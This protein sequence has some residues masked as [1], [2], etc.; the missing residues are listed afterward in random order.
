ML[1][2]G[3]GN[4]LPTIFSHVNFAQPCDWLASFV[5]CRIWHLETHVLL[6][7][8]GLTHTFKLSHMI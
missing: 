3:L 5:L 6:I 2:T 8:E 1:N 4:V 7:L